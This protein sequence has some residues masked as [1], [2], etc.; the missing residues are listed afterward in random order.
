[1]CKGYPASWQPGQGQSANSKA[2]ALSPTGLPSRLRAGVQVA[3][4]TY[5]S[6]PARG[7]QGRGWEEGG[8]GGFWAGPGGT[9]RKE[10]RPLGSRGRCVRPR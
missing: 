7:W 8:A 5:F 6:R 9:S 10:L 4:E 1:M 2:S 3:F